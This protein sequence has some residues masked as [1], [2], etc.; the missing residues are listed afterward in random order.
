[1]AA[2]RML[3]HKGVIDA[4]A[5]C[6]L[7]PM[8]PSADEEDLL[9][10]A[11]YVIRLRQWGVFLA[12]DADVKMDAD[13]EFDTLARFI[14]AQNEEIERERQTW[15]ECYFCREKKESV[16]TCWARY[17]VPPYDVHTHDPCDTCRSEKGFFEGDGPEY[18]EY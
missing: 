13:G 14:D 1:M 15:L 5:T 11:A 16:V 8:A 17:E 9:G 12:S 2:F 7:K 4:E 10:K 3:E 6:F 18:S